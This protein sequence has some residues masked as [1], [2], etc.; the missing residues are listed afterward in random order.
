MAA[1]KT[2]IITFSA[3]SDGSLT[4]QVRNFGEDLLRQ[5][6]QDGLGDVGGIEAIDGATDT[7]RVHI[8]HTRK[9]GTVRKLVDKLLR[10]H[11]LD[12]Q[13]ELLYS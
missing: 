10:A 5:I 7:I 12:S 13:S 11:V 9:I 8:H 6:E 1:Q 4:H 3:N 2:I